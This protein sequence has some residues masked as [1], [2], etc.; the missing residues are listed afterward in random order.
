MSQF[1]RLSDSMLASPQI[2]VDDVAAAKAGL[3]PRELL[4]QHAGG[5]IGPAT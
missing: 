1:R 3:D 5:A 2:T 4:C